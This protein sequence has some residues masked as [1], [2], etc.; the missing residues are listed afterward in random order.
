MEGLA[1]LFLGKENMKILTLTSDFE[2]AI[3]NAFQEFFDDRH[4]ALRGCIFH[5]DVALGRKIKKL[6]LTDIFG[7]DLKA[8]LHGLVYLNL[9]SN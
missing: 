2:K 9:Q 3:R 5:F 6:N 4:L 1:N 8:I 7:T